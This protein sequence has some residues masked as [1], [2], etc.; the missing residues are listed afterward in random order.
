MHRTSGGTGLYKMCKSKGYMVVSPN[1]N[2]LQ[3]KQCVGAI[4]GFTV[5]TMHPSLFLD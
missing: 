2:D 4:A 3:V 5:M 1:S